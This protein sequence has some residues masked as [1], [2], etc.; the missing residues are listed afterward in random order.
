M[1]ELNV[2]K[3]IM[4]EMIMRK[5]PV[6]K[7]SSGGKTFYLVFGSHTKNEWTSRGK[8]LLRENIGWSNPSCRILS[9][10][11]N[12]YLNNLNWYLQALRDS[13]RQLNAFSIY[14]PEYLQSIGPPSKK[15]LYMNTCVL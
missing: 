5:P 14:L 2:S 8:I 13:K 4:V 12:G 7:R 10:I 1:T 6:E 15:V 3:K 11:Y 9:R